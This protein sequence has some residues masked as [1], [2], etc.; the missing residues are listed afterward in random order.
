MSHDDKYVVFKKAE[1][2]EWYNRVLKDSVPG[3]PMALDDAVVI[4]QQDVFAP[5]A[6][7]VYANGI[8][9]AL[10]LTATG[11]ETTTRLRET[12]DYFH[13]RAAE[14]WHMKRKLPD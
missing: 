4:R 1:F 6:L 13:T 3:V 7:D 12:A 8:E 10:S 14:S 5:P 9:V 11:G 2:D